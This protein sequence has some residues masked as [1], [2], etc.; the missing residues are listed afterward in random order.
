MLAI[1][2]KTNSPYPSLLDSKFP[3][4]TVYVKNYFKVDIS[5]GLFY[6][7][8][9]NHSYSIA[10][11]SSIIKSSTGADSTK[12]GNHIVSENVGSNE[13]GFA[14]FVH[15]YY[16]WGNDV[17]VSLTLGAGVNFVTTVQPRYFT[18]VSLLL[19]HDNRFCVNTGIEFGN[20]KLLSD[21]YVKDANGVYNVTPGTSSIVYKTQFSHALFI[22]LSYNLPFIKS[23]TSV[24]APAT[25]SN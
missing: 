19:G 24:A 11:D 5:S 4:Q 12:K 2:K 6:G 15:L 23:K 16:K 7:F 8:M 3:T 21:Q 1:T 25:V 10:A 9:K 13:L 22:S 20:Q 17:N 18:G 14:S